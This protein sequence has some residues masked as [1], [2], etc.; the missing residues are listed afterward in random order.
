MLWILWPC[1]IDWSSDIVSLIHCLLLSCRKGQGRPDW[2][3]FGRLTQHNETTLFKEKFVDWSDSRKTPSPTRHTNNHVT[4]QK[5][6]KVLHSKVWIMSKWDI[7]DDTKSVPLSWLLSSPQEPSAADPRHAY[8]ASLM[9][10]PHEG[11]VCSTLD[12]FN[13]GRGYGLVEAED[14]RSYKIST[15]AV[16]VW[17]IL[18]FDY[19]RQPRQSIGQFHEGDTYVVKW[20]YMVSTAG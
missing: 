18:E 7:E 9:L 1:V 15:Q 6:P 17:H 11:P 19:S 8:D 13:V 2:A 4:D 16:E 14:W 5:V 10:Q 12:G 3:V 20:K